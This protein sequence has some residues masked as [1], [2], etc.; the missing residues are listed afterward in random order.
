[1][2]SDFSDSLIF[3]SSHVT[4]FGRICNITQFRCVVTVTGGTFISVNGNSLSNAY[5]TSNIQVTLPTRFPPHPH[6]QPQPNSYLTRSR[7]SSS[8]T[9]CF[10]DE[11]DENEQD[12]IEK[13]RKVKTTSTT[14]ATT[15]TSK[16]L[17]KLADKITFSTP[18]DDIENGILKFDF[19]IFKRG[20]DRYTSSRDFS[21]TC[22]GFAGG[23]FCGYVLKKGVK[24]VI[25]VLLG[26]VASIILLDTLGYIQLQEQLHDSGIL[27]QATKTLR[28]VFNFER[29]NRNSTS[30]IEDKLTGLQQHLMTYSLIEGSFFSGLCVGF[31]FG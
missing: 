19:H 22:R 12:Y 31:S 29:P 9:I 18:L 27:D 16:L 15:T 4:M 23:L 25:F 10:C 28:S 7:T 14:K 8:S 26:G 30:V 17:Q 11:N 6:P 2:C 3:P 21:L 1:M 24:T 20:I 13:Q 5:Q